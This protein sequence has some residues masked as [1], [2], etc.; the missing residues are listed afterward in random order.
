ME[1]RPL[2]KADNNNHAGATS[3]F[4]PSQRLGIKICGVTRPDQAEAIIAAG[5]DALGINLWEGSRR[6]VPLDTAR[7]WLG[8]LRGRTFRVA[9]VVNAS[10]EFL[11][12]VVASDLFDA[13]QLHGDEAPEVVAGLMGRGVCVIKALQVR[14]R[15]SLDAIAAY[16]TRMLLLDAFN[17]GLHGGAGRAFPWDLAVE[18]KRR[19]P[20]RHIILAGGLT[21]RNVRS[22]VRQVRPAAVDVASG[23]ESAP[24]IKD[25]TLVRRFIDE[26]R[27]A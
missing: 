11:D 5:A 24:G 2:S 26:A 9:V 17:P 12:E 7:S 22:A 19:H 8:S 1:N 15:E 20:D 4:P 3:T 16:P 13:L 14:D 10:D 6:F 18:A 21:D 23:V 27:A 25:M